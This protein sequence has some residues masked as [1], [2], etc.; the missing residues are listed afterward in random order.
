MKKSKF[1]FILIIS[2]FSVSLAS[3]QGYVD[4]LYYNRKNK[5][6]R[7]AV[8]KA[9]RERVAAER[10]KVKKTVRVEEEDEI[11]ISDE[12]YYPGMFADMVNGDNSNAEKAGKERTESNDS[13]SSVIIV[14]LWSPSWYNYSSWGNS[15]YDPFGYGGG[16]Y[17]P[18]YRYGWGYNRWN[19]W[20][21]WNNPYYYG[22]GWGHGWHNPHYSMG[23][24]GHYHG[25]GGYYEP[26][27]NRVNSTIG[28]GRRQAGT[29]VG[30]SSYGRGNSSNYT[31]TNQIRRMDRN[32]NVN[33][34]NNR[35]PNTNTT[36]NRRPNTNTT[37][38][39]RQSQNNR[40]DTYSPPPTTNSGSFGTGS[41]NRGGNVGTG[42]GS[43]AGSGSGTTTT[44]RRR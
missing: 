37:V 35:R 7:E 34:M 14:G 41:S 29:M 40:R 3:A 28:N 44:S 43:G 10:A 26:R 23:W 24:G 38:N 15:F 18:F 17:D 27:Y 4:D 2:I 6:E 30:T 31:V 36:I 39:P 16:F 19:G 21:G 12:E 9:E 33:S 1:L 42:S 32:T 8:Q 20:N 11:D 22:G 13:K 5:S 25:H